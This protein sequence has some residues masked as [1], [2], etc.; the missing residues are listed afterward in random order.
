MKI[1]TKIINGE[2][3]IKDNVHQLNKLDEPSIYSSLEEI[4]LILDEPL[5]IVLD[6]HMRHLNQFSSTTFLPSDFIEDVHFT[7]MVLEIFDDN[8]KK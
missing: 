5:P 6:K 8:P 4:C 2:K 7:K 1:W 3:I